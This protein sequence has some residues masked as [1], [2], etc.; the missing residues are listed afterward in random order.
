MSEEEQRAVFESQLRECFG[1]VVYSHKT[2]EKCADLFHVRSKQIK[3]GQV[4]LSAL[5]TGAFL[6]Q[7]FG[8]SN[9][10]LVI[11]AVLSTSLICLNA[12]TK[13]YD[14]GKVAQQHREAGT[15]LWD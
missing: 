1:R 9:I 2:H 8:K 15:K 6:G 7:I 5:T 13:D 12:Y 11:G 14:L 3:T 10:G 4:I